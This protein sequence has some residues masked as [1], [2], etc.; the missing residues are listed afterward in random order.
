MDLH[1]EMA[2]DLDEASLT[3]PAHLK[4]LAS[5]DDHGHCAIASG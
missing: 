5:F 2:G 1:E 3:H 4:R